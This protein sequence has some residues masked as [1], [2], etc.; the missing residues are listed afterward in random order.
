MANATL[1]RG[2]KPARLPS[3]SFDGGFPSF[4]LRRADWERIQTQYKRVVPPTVRRRLR[5]ATQDYIEEATFEQQAVS[6]QV[7]LR[8]LSE[9]RKAATHFE[10]EV[11]RHLSKSDDSSCYAKHLILKY[12]EVCTSGNTRFA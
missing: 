4:T 3:A 11:K 1:A 8:K 10:R 7:A 2:P 9:V 12:G 5:A 6:K